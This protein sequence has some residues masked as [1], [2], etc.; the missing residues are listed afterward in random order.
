[1]PFEQH[2]RGVA[3]SKRVL[4]PPG[5]FAECH[6]D[7]EALEMGAVPVAGANE[8]LLCHLRDGPFVHNTVDQNLTVLEKQLPPMHQ[9]AAKS[10]HGV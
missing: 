10:N 6:C 2:V 3:C 5:L 4:S 1:M 9:C 7:Y 8:S